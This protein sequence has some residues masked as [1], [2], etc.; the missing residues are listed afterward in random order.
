MTT[1]LRQQLISLTL[2]VLVS[3]SLLGGLDRLATHYGQAAAS[4]T[5]A[6]T[7]AATSAVRPAG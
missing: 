6:A 4:P 7:P 3:V 1:P 2:A 5:W